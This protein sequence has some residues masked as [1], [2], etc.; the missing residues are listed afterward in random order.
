MLSAVYFRLHDEE[1][2]LRFFE[3]A[4]EQGEGGLKVFFKIFPEGTKNAKIQTIINKD[5]KSE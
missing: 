4:V 3:K 1:A 5:Q 2:G